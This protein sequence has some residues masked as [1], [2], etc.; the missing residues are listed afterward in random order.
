MISLSRI[1][2]SFQTSSLQNEKKII[3][4]KT[5]KHETVNDCAVDE[6]QRSQSIDQVLLE[7][8]LEAKR[9]ID[10]AKNEAEQIRAQ[11]TEAKQAWE[12]ERK[13]LIEEAQQTGY[14][15]GLTEGREQGYEEMKA[16]IQ[17]AKHVI[18]VAKQDYHEKIDAAEGTILQL[19]IKVAEKII[20]ASLEKDEQYYLSMI[21]AVLKE[22]RE[23]R[24]V[25]IHVHPVYYEMILSEK[26]ELLTLFPGETSLYIYPDDELSELDCFIES[27]N[28]RI[29]ASVDSQLA[30]IK[31][32]LF[33]LLESE[34]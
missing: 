23:D 24:E 13:M 4:I 2:K 10:Q 3:E 20:G 27:E 16:S 30:E 14:Q 32:K 26:E 8:E 31:Q 29:D 17:L 28:G 19:A 25:Q 34:K 33:E 9:R 1:F 7:A 21:K 6:E 18:D 5:I 11:I 12:Q 22:V 15:A